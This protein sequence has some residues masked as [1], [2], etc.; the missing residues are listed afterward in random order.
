MAPY[1]GATPES[2]TKQ[3]SYDLSSAGV[4]TPGV[5]YSSKDAAAAFDEIL[6][7]SEVLAIAGPLIGA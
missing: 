4:P 5:T 2:N 3:A 6:T 1:Q 7:V